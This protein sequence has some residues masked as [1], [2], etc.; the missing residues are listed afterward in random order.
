MLVTLTTS[1]SDPTE[2]WWGS[3]VATLTVEPSHVAS[4]MKLKFLCW[5][6]LARDPLPK[7]VSIS[8]LVDPI[9]VLD[10]CIINPSLGALAVPPSLGKT[11]LAL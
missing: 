5:V 8:V 2:R 3:S 4:A 1:T 6:S 7:Y 9:A 11:Y 10:S